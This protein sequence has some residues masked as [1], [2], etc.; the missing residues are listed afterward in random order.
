VAVL[1]VASFRQTIYSTT[2][3]H[4]KPDTPADK[5]DYFVN[6]LKFDKYPMP[7]NR[8]CIQEICDLSDTTH[9]GIYEKTLSEVTDIPGEFSQHCGVF[10]VLRSQLKDYLAT[11]QPQILRWSSSTGSKYIPANLICYTFGS[12]KGLGFDRV[13]IILSDKHLKFIRGDTTVSDSDKTD[14]SRN[15]LYVAITRARYSLAFLVEDKLVKGLPYPVWLGVNALAD[16]EEN[17]IVDSA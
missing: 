7:T 14:S 9:S 13:L 5:I 16:G 12:S 4:K 10:I 17:P 15:K 1:L 6:K 3:G 11:F 8:R 2:F